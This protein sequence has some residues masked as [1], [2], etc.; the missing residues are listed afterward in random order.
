MNSYRYRLETYK[1]NGTRYHCPECRQKSFVRYFDT[2]TGEHI[3]LKVGRCNREAK[4]GY[5]YSP[6]QYFGDSNLTA[7]NTQHI[8][9]TNQ[10]RTTVQIPSYITTAAF[11]ASLR[12]YNDNYFVQYLYTLFD[13]DTVIKL[14]TT[15]HIGTS[16]Y[17]KGA[18]VFWQVD[19]SN[20]V[21][22]GKVMLYDSVTGKRVKE[23]YSHITWAHKPLN[24]P[25]FNLKQ[26]LFGE[27]LL[28]DSNKP[29]A[30]VESEKTAVI[31]SVYQPK[32]VWLAVGSLS[33]L[34][35]EKCSAL[36]GR[37]VVLYP[38]L[39]GFE[40]WSEKLRGLRSIGSFGID[41]VLEEVATDE[42]RKQG[43]DI[44]DY[45]VQYSLS[46]FTD[47][48]KGVKTKEQR[49]EDKVAD[50]FD[51]SVWPKVGWEEEKG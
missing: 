9:Y 4:C 20:N 27:H 50:S 13:A 30:I 28:K 7:T 12:S 6:K 5:H 22:T 47:L 31:A 39:N 37:K 46:E 26:C 48:D 11:N 24:Q 35:A 25:D 51:D 2:Q 49:Q 41:S 32:Y 33:N 21:R 3:N 36:K 17:W 14:V 15:Y 1:G 8:G 42:E 16:K 23:P 44:A 40:K 19:S 10:S 29:I 43:L 34:T 38:D 18:T 45:F